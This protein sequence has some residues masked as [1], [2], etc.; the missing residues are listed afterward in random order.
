MQLPTLWFPWLAQSSTT[1]PLDGSLGATAQNGILVALGCVVAGL[2]QIAVAA[3]G[4]GRNGKPTP[5]DA[6]V[7]AIA[8]LEA[9]YLSATGALTSAITELRVTV[10]TQGVKLDQLLKQTERRHTS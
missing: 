7:P 4:K 6:L 1:V 5:S 9:S 8:R 10:A 3:V 2:V